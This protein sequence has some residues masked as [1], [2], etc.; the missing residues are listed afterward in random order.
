MHIYYI[1]SY[2]YI[3]KMPQHGKGMQKGQVRTGPT[4][5]IRYAD[6]RIHILNLINVK[7][8]R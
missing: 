5:P 7:Y 8:V 4:N 6:T 3:H 2:T 1:Y